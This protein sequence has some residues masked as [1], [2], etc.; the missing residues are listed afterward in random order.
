MNTADFKHFKLHSNSTLK[1]MTKEELI[2][3]IHMLHYNWGACDESYYNVMQYAKLLDKAL[4]KACEKLR[5]ETVD[6]FRCPGEQFG[7]VPSCCSE[8][9]CDGSNME[10]WKEWCMN[11][12]EGKQ[13]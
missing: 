12:S 7:F 3:Y 6:D 2:S 5:D 4:D 13:L 11:A 10:C 1:S 9:S 8:E